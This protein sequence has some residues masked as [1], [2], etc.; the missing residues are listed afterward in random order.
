MTPERL[1]IRKAVAATRK[2]MEQQAYSLPKFKHL[3]K[4]I[5]GL[6]ISILKRDR[7]ENE[8]KRRV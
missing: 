5:R 2:H 8:L 1:A 3:R 4:F 6:S 7:T